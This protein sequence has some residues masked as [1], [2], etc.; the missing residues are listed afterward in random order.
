MILWYG[1]YIND[2][3]TDP[4]EIAESVLTD[5]RET[6]PLP[7]SAVPPNI[8]VKTHF[9]HLVKVLK[10][11][12]GIV[13]WEQKGESL[14]DYIHNCQQTVKDLE[15]DVKEYVAPSPCRAGQFTHIMSYI[16][17]VAGNR[18]HSGLRWGQLRG[19]IVV[20]TTDSLETTIQKVHKTRKA[21]LKFRPCPKCGDRVDFCEKFPN[22]RRFPIIDESI[23]DINLVKNFNN[24]LHNYSPKA[25]PYFQG[26][27]FSLLAAN[28]T[29]EYLHAQRKRRS[30]N[31]FTRT[32]SND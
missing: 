26:Y 4:I 2:E 30:T 22:C 13:T 24:H 21:L 10:K 8:D 11:L 3:T 19:T 31:Y 27:K 12:T 16:D 25:D 17:K 28:K 14:D 32:A 9:S 15:A 7:L 23:M 1:L 5:F 6:I 18:F 20:P 29:D